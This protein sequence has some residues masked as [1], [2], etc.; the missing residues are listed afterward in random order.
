M[1]EVDALGAVLVTA[2][3]PATVKEPEIA[4]PVTGSLVVI[5]IVLSA[6]L[7][8]VNVGATLSAALAFAPSASGFDDASITSPFAWT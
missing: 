8:A 5:T 6:V 3:D 7:D 4:V 2:P 1:I